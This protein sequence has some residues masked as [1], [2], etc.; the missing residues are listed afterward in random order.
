M[1]PYSLETSSSSDRSS[2]IE[3]GMIRYV[4]T[5]GGKPFDITKRYT[6]TWVGGS[7]RWQIV[8]DDTSAVESKE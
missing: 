8:A 4:G 2:A 5:N 1:S 6:A 3:T 7:G